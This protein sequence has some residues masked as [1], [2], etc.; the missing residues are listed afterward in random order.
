MKTNLYSQ[1]PHGQLLLHQKER[2]YSLFE[3]AQ[4]LGLP[5]SDL[6]EI[7]DKHALHP[8]PGLRGERIARREV[9]NYVSRHPTRLAR[10]AQVVSP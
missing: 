4:V 6:R 7:L 2:T 3:T 1:T 10:A 9:L 5:L 8:E